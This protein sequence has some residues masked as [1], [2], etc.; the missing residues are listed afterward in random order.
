A[1]FVPP[2]KQ[3]ANCIGCKECEKR[4]PQGIKISEWMPQIHEKLGKK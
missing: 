4:C 1:M 2:E 3:T